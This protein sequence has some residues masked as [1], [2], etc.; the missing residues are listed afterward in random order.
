MNLKQ[1]TIV[2]GIAFSL[3]IVCAFVSSL[4]MSALFVLGAIGV[5]IAWVSEL[6]KVFG[7]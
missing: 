7:V 1:K 6:L 3:C 2:L 4:P 5:V